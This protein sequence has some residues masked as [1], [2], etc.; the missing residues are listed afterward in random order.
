MSILHWQLAACTTAIFSSPRKTTFV[1]TALPR[2]LSMSASTFDAKYEN[3]LMS[4]PVLRVMLVTLNRPKALNALN[5][6]LF[7][8]LNK[9]LCLIDVDKDI[10]T[11]VITRSEKV[12]SGE[13]LAIALVLGC[14]AQHHQLLMDEQKAGADIKEMKDKSC[15]C[16]AVN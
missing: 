7:A 1:Y 13:P 8:E 2:F 12:F 14:V 16:S 4:H 11:I 3:I 5:A 6:V 9:A 10:G 15:E